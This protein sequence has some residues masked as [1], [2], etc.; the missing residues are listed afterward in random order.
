MKAESKN[1]QESNFILNTLNV[2]SLQEVL[3]GS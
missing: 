3:Y 1:M 2:Y